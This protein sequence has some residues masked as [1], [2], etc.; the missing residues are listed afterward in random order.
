MLRFVARGRFVICENLEKC[1]HALGGVRD[2]CNVATV[3]RVKEKLSGGSTL[4]S[5][6]LIDSTTP[7]TAA[8]TTHREHRR[9]SS[10][11]AV[12]EIRKTCLYDLHV[13]KQ[14]KIVNFA[15][16]LL[17]VQYREAI[18]V[19]H[20]HTRSFASLFDVGHMLQTRVSGKDAGEYLESLTTCDLK[21]L[22]NGAATLTVFTNDKGGI[23][24]D[25]IIT[26]D[27]EDR[28]FVVS[29]AGRRDEDCQLLLE[30]LGDFKTIGKHVYVDFLDPREQGLIALQGPT[31]A[32][33]LQSLVKIDLRNLKFM[34]SVK[35]EVSGSRIRISRCG[36]TG[37]DGFEISVPGND[38]INLVERILEIPDVKL[39]GLG[40]RDS[41]RLEAGLCLYGHDI[42]ENTTPIEAALTWLVA[43][44]R[45]AEANFPG[46]QRILSQIKTGTT[47]KRVGLLLGQGPPAREGAPILTPEGERVG[48]VTSGG[49]SPTLGRPIAMGYMP[50]D[51]AQFGGGVLVE[52]R[53]KTYK[54][55][56]TRMPFVKAKYYTAK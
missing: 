54:G 43:K 45:R 9:L 11:S 25:L 27:D 10:T 53:G 34:N 51:L 3:S 28:Y 4:H 40:A 6:C 2:T 1:L 17:P 42:N 49:P 7:R 36:Y 37:E 23:L 46:A 30:R 52:V 47:K 56:V 38:A 48:S 5:N 8:E 35:T 44:R 29:N 39:A 33:V 55:T 18:A 22:S 16:W 21:N 31:A 19:S 50:P 32:T 14:G 20:L 41:L 12:S 13:E 24:D 15:G 26:R